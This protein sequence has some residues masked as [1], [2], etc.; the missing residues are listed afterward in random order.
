VP[1]FKDSV[2]ETAVVD[3]YSKSGNQVVNVGAMDITVSGED[4]ANNQLVVKPPASGITQ[5]K[6]HVPAENTT[7]TIS[8]AAATAGTGLK[9]VVT[10]IQASIH[11]SDAAPTA[12]APAV[13]SLTDGTTV[14]WS[15]KVAVPTVAGQL[16]QI[17]IPN[18]GIVGTAETAMTLAFAAGAGTDTF[19]CVSF[20][21]V[22]IL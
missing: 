5:W 16:N 18:L 10:S 15:A 1:H 19:E 14:V 9:H 21:Y 13:L 20:T 8:A 4:Q 6:Y 22:D 7:A 3:L 11:A 2:T 17:V 12:A